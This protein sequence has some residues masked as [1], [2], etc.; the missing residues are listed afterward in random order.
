MDSVLASQFT[1]ASPGL[2]LH[3]LK[4]FSEGNYLNKIIL[5]LQRFIDAPAKRQVDRGLI[6][7]NE[8]I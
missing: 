4:S 3:V 6:M 1:P 8:P 5:M 2:I 7:S